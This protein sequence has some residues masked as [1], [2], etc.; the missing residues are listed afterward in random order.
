VTVD[1]SKEAIAARQ[2]A[3]ATT[4]RDGGWTG[5]ELTEI[6]GRGLQEANRLAKVTMSRPPGR[7]RDRA[8]RKAD[9]TLLQAATQIRIAQLC[10][11]DRGY[12][13]ALDLGQIQTVKDEV[14]RLFHQDAGAL[15]VDTH[16]RLQ[17]QRTRLS[18][19]TTR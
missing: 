7:R 14:T 6:A 10:P 5:R 13:H 8:S 17:L 12:L 1:L 2:K 19:E 9:A 16:R 4:Q 11:P 18:K 15:A 3:K